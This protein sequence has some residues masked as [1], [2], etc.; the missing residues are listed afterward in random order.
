MTNP[1]I[2]WW[3]LTSSL[4]TTTLAPERSSSAIGITMTTG[5]VLA[6]P[7]GFR[8][9]SPP[10][11]GRCRARRCRAPR[12]SDKVPNADE[13]ALISFQIVV[14]TPGEQNAAN[15]LRYLSETTIVSEIAREIKAGVVMIERACAY[16]RIYLSTCEGANNNLQIATTARPLRTRS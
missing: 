2:R 11:P 5:V 13:T 14:T 7:Y 10:E 15:A 16:T 8:S 12:G 4:T 9:L 1:R 3:S 6:L